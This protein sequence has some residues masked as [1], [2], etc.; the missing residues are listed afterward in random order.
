L[1]DTSPQKLPKLVTRRLLLRPWEMSDVG[2]LHAM[3][4]HPEVRRYL[5]DGRMVSRE[6]VV[7]AV[8]SHLASSAAFRIGFWMV[9]PGENGAAAGFCGFR[10]QEG[11]SEIEL[12]YGLL[13]EYWGQGFA[14]ESSQAALD[15]VWRNTRFPR[16]WAHTD[17]PNIKSVAVLERLGMRVSSST[18]ARI[19]FL[20]ER[21]GKL[22]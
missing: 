16:V 15:Y 14:T 7:E 2:T 17:P 12:L 1:S 3:W 6:Q 11:G 9:S 5:W 18:P 20:I 10:L 19:S 21:G 4:N 22:D 13:P 8:G